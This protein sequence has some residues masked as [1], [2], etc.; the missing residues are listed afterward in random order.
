MGWRALVTDITLRGRPAGEFS[1]GIVY[2]GLEK[3]LETGTSSTGALLSIMGGG[4]FTGK[5]ER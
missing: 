2:R 1:R 3:A 5:S 4:L